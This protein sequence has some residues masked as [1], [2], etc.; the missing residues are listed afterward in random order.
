MN[1]EETPNQPVVSEY[2]RVVSEYGKVDSEDNGYKGVSESEFN[3]L[4]WGYGVAIHVGTIILEWIKHGHF[5]V[6][7]V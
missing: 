6:F 4:H 3:R 2:D 5:R 1:P 7:L